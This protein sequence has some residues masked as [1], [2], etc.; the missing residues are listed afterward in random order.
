MD[1]LKAERATL[2]TR[3]TK[4]LTKL[5]PNVIDNL[6]A[7]DL[8]V[9][10]KKVATYIDNLLKLDT[11]IN[12][13]LRLTESEGNMVKLESICEDYEDKL[14]KLHFIL[15]AKLNAYNAVQSQIQPNSQSMGSAMGI[16]RTKLHLPNI[17][18]PIFYAD[19][20]K[21]TLSCRAFI[22]TL[23][24]MWNNYQLNSVEK[25]ALL[26]KQC[27]KRAKTMV[28]SLTLQN[29]SYDTAKSIL[30][31]AFDE[32]VPQQYSV[33]KQ[34]TEL[35]LKCKGDP[36]VYYSNFMKIVETLKEE[37]IDSNLMIQYFVW[38][39]LPVDFQ[40]QLITISQSSY[41]DLDSIKKHFLA[42]CSR[43][44]AHKENSKADMEV[45]AHAMSLK[46]N[47]G[48]DFKK[49]NSKFKKSNSQQ[50]FAPCC[51]CKSTLH[52]NSKCDKYDS[53]QA[54]QDRIREIKLCCKCLKTS[55]HIANECDFRLK[56]GCYYCSKPHWSFLCLK[57]PE[58][59][60]ENSNTHTNAKSSSQDKGSG[61]SE[62]S[63]L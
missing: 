34:L 58:K 40:D 57:R 39:G 38:S 42:T 1:A 63:S 45:S 25:Y 55:D 49:P 22:A 51:F 23:E 33:I 6:D 29:R 60:C 30:L 4:N 53:A 54:K 15:K 19:P 27:E 11:N 50:N 59:S 10:I 46:T 9:N 44:E 56:S 17:E 13:Q 5:Q 43:F 16:N 47:K 2:R 48:N 26:L 21:D 36:Y 62:V 41:P 31:A 3:A 12:A 7:S 18:L 35:K 24:L 61:N 8:D 14:R 37:K 32:V 28:E 52:K 20:K